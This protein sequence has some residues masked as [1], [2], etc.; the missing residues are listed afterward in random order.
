MTPPAQLLSVPNTL[1][2]DGVGIGLD[3]VMAGDRAGQL[4][5]GG[6]GDAAVELAV[7]HDLPLAGFLADLDDG[8]AMGGHL[9]V[10]LLL[11]RAGCSTLTLPSTIVTMPGNI[12]CGLVYSWLT[13]QQAVLGRAVER[14]VA[15][16]V[17]VVAELPGLGLAPS[18]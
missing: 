1:V 7:A 2:P 12:R 18:G 15:D 5:F 11:G 10:D 16:I 3:A 6:G 4:H 17:V 8:A 14:D 9:D 13:T